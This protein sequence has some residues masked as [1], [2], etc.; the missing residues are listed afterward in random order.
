[1]LCS[2][3]Y[4]RNFKN[5]FSR[6]KGLIIPLLVFLIY[7]IFTHS[8]YD[9]I[10]LILLGL[11]DFGT[12]NVESLP[13]I[14]IIALIIFTY[15]IYDIIKNKNSKNIYITYYAL[16]GLA[17]TVPIFDIN[18]ILGPIFLFLIVIFTKLDLKLKINTTIVNILLVVAYTM[19]AINIG[20][21][22]EFSSFNHYKFLPC[23]SDFSKNMDNVIYSYKKKYPNSIIVSPYAPLYD[24]IADKKIT[25]FDLTLTGNY[26]HLGTQ[27]IINMVEDNTY[28][29]IYKNYNSKEISQFDIKLC[30]HIIKNSKL[31]DSVGEYDIYY[32]V[33]K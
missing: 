1:M 24:T 5:I 28:Y 21:S 4:I 27:K 3:I 13:I 18:H 33:K 30:N 7:L 19:L 8:L 11:F 6:F 25:Y 29:F 22:Q 10:D 26:G 20:T 14:P 32:Y 23:A 17:L 15:Y 9:C 31:V 2:F 12:K 16:G